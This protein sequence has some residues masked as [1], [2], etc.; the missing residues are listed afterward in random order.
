MANADPVG[1]ALGFVAA[2]AQAGYALIAGRGYA[3]LPAAQAAVAVTSVIGR[4]L[5]P[6]RALRRRHLEP[7]SSRSRPATHGSGSSSPATLGMALPT[8]AV[9]SGYRRLGP[10]PASI[11]MLLEPVVA[12]VLAAVLLAERPAPLQLLGGLLVLSGSL[13][14]Q[15]RG[16]PE[17]SAPPV[18]GVA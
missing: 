4:R 5:R 17:R 16:Q 2:F 9:L 8:A 7:E 18:S 11:L 15:V 1:L 6:R 12:V 13:L 3:S 10:T 14:A